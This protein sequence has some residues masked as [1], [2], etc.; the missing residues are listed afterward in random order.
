MNA[1][2]TQS[3]NDKNSYKSVGC[4]LWIHFGWNMLISVYMSLSKTEI[5]MK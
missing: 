5:Y 2:I 4:I 3:V 1:L